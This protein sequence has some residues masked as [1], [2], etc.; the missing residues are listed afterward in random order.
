MTL[1]DEFISVEI[2]ECKKEKCKNLDISFTG[3]TKIPYNIGILD[4]LEELSMCFNSLSTLPKSIQ[5][6]LS[7]QSLDLSHTGIENLP[8]EF[9]NLKN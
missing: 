5:K 9:S 7:L 2:E 3:L 6:L 1:G 8:E 4:Q